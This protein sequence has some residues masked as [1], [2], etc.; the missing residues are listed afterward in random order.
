[1]AASLFG[2]PQQTDIGGRG[3]QGCGQGLQIMVVTP[4]GDNNK[5]M[6][7]DGQAIKGMSIILDLHQAAWGQAGRQMD[8]P[9]IGQGHPKPDEAGQGCQ[10]QAHMPGPDDDQRGR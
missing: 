8:I 10:G 3:A 5:S 2:A 7:T 6:L 1:M 4:G 9:V